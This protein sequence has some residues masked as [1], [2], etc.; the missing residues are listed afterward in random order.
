MYQAPPS[1]RALGRDKS[2]IPGVTF[3]SCHDLIQ[4]ET[5]SSLNQG[6]PPRMLRVHILVKPTFAF[7]LY[8][9]F[10]TRLS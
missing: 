10:L 7:A 5:W 4:L 8:N 9:G 3:R 2:V 6:F 1:I